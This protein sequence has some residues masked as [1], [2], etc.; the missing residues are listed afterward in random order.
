MTDATLAYVPPPPHNLEAEQAVLGAILFDNRA[1]E[2]VGGDLTPEHFYEPYHGRL[3]ELI[4]DRIASGGLADPTMLVDSLRDDPAFATNGGLR[5]LA[6]LME[7]APA[8]RVAG[9]YA[10]PII[11]AA[12][13]RR[14]IE[15]SASLSHLAR[16][17]DED[18]LQVASTAIANLDEIVAGAAPDSSTMVDARTSMQATVE[19]LLHDH[20]HGRARGYQTGIRCFDHRLGGL[21]PQKL[22][23]VGGRP[24]MGKSGLARAAAYGAAR[25]N[26]SHDFILFGV[27]MDREEYDLRTLGEISYREGRGVHYNRLGEPQNVD[28]ET[29]ERLASFVDRAPSN[30]LIDDSGLL[31]LE[32]VRRRLMARRRKRQVAAIFID[33]LQIMARP[34]SRGR[35]EASVIGEITAGLKQLARSTGVC[36]VLLS[37]LSRQV[38]QRDNKRPMLSDLRESGSIEQ[39]ADAVLFCYRE[40]Y[41]LQREGAKKGQS[42][43]EHD[44]LLQSVVTV[45]EVICA[46]RRGGPIGTD[47]Q[48]YLAQYDVI[49]NEGEWL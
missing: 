20:T 18:A 37:Q 45:M 16:S 35:N 27:E 11:E 24:S 10:G 15:I 25:L 17:S 3:F 48:R 32:H 38:E 22:I 4:R 43:A 34:D 21:V 36:I 40:H 28:R 44:L 6:D 26:P 13:R 2:A 41:Y 23:V 49:E 7:R 42:E 46:K 29:L 33:Y 47:R 30:L 14:L 19:R 5:Y 8:P 12:A 1:F 39:D 9:Q 31:S